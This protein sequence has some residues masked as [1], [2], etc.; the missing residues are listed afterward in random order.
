MKDH[1]GNSFDSVIDMCRHYGVNINTFYA[2]KAKGWTLEQALTKSGWSVR[3]HLGHEYK[4]LREM[5]NAHG[6]S[7]DTYHKRRAKGLSLEQALSKVR[8]VIQRESRKVRDHRGNEYGS[9]KEMA[10]A[11]GVS[12]ST[13][14]QRRKR[15]WTL[16]ETL[17]KPMMPSLGMRKQVRDHL[18]NEYES[19]KEMLE[20]YGVKYITYHNRLKIGMSVEEALTSPDMR[21]GKRTKTTMDDALS[22]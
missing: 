11:Y 14:K 15:G 17:T 2:R 16:K 4:N 22:E 10:K 7:Y 8:V 3:D 18:G 5:T 21:G 19:Q 9:L 6:I 13:F 12:Y 20:A 1:A